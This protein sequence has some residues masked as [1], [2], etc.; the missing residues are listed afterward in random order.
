[1]KLNKE[2]LNLL[3]HKNRKEI[4]GKIISISRSKLK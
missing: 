1:M 2:N 3:N 4:R